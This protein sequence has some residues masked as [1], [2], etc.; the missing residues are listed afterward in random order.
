MTG[1]DWTTDDMVMV[2]SDFGNRAFLIALEVQ[3]R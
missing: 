1:L 2:V 3:P